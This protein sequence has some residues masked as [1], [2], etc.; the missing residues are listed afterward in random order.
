[1]SFFRI[2]E[3]SARTF[4]STS[5]EEDVVSALVLDMQPHPL[6]RFNP[7][8]PKRTLCLVRTILYG[9]FAMF[10]STSSE[11]DVVS[12]LG[13]GTRTAQ[14]CFNPRPPKRALCLYNQPC[15]LCRHGR[16]NPRPPKRTL[17]PPCL[18]ALQLSHKFQSTSSE[19]DV[20]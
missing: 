4:Q 3:D 7:R 19:E 9:F 14:Y 6:W 13:A 17:C 15:S 11:E 12:Y 10:Q 5:S 2:V 20:V 16:F 18:S 1:M 8:P